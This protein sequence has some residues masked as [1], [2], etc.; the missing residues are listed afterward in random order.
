MRAGFDDDG[1]LWGPQAI[2]ISFHMVVMV[3]L[4]ETNPT[5]GVTILW[6]LYSMYVNQ[7][8]LVEI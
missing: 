2:Q 8:F 7:L 1:S 5:I 4:F 3:V 6:T